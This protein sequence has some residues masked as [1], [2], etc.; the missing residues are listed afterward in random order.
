[1]LSEKLG[2]GYLCVGCLMCRK[3][4]QDSNLKQASEDTSLTTPPSAPHGTHSDA[5][6]SPR[7]VYKNSKSKQTLFAI[8]KL[9]YRETNNSDVCR[10]LTAV[11]EATST[12]MSATVPGMDLKLC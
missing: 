1:M 7:R 3:G 12:E 11:K 2:E 6:L 4:R 8:D 5:L 9:K 10:G